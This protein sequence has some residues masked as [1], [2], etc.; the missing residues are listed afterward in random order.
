MLSMPFFLL[1]RP[2]PRSTLFPYTTLFRSLAGR[3]QIGAADA[4]FVDHVLGIELRVMIRDHPARAH[5][6]ADLFVRLGEQDDVARQRN[7]LTLQFEEGEDVRHA[8]SLHV[9]SAARPQVIA[10]SGGP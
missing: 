7:A 4:A 5:R 6:A 10:H 1:I 8:L 9:E 3:E 2:P